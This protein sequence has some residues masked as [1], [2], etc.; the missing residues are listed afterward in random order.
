[1]FHMGENEAIAHLGN[2]YSVITDLS[3]FLQNLRWSSLRGKSAQVDRA[4][5]TSPSLME[6][7]PD[8]PSDRI[9]H[10]LPADLEDRMGS[11]ILN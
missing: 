7:F 11:P 5:D 6:D 8:T 3:T 9:A 1:M 2:S 10:K 4:R